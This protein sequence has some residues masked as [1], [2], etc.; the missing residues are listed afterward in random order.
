MPELVE[1]GHIYIAQPP[2]YKIKHGKTERYLKDDQALNQFLLTLAL[3]DAVLTPRAGAAE[4]SGSALAELARE[5]LLAEAV[6]NRLSHMINPQVL[7]ALIDA[8]LTM[9]LRSDESA[10]LSANALMDVIGRKIGVHIL[11]RYDETQERWQLV[12]EKMHHG[13]LKVGVINEDLLV[14][15]D[16]AQLR[17][18][19]EL[20]AGLYGPGGFVARGE[21]RQFVG[22]FAETMRWLLAEVE[23]GVSKQRYKGLGEMNPEQLWETTMDPAVRRLLK[24]QIEDAIGADEIFTTLMGELVEPRRNF[25]ELTALAARNIDV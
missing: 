13:N 15:G 24:V 11:A 9:D 14:S 3:E 8:N 12:L 16:Y 17:K 22:S 23:R 1:G 5:Y 21:K 2:L 20:L 19:A 4:I 25:I 10:R 18:T 7:Y 6:I